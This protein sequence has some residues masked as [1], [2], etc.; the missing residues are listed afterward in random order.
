MTT[1]DFDT[2]FAAFLVEAQARVNN[3]Y[4]DLGAD[5]APTLSAEPGRRFIRIVADNGHQRSAWAF[6]DRENGDVLKCD[7]WKRP[8]KGARG[9]IYD[10]HKGCGRV[11]WT[12][13]R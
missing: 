9:N 4:A 10:E 11:L 8:A 6:V 12:G 7:G 13:V 1:D 5:T 2:A 3:D